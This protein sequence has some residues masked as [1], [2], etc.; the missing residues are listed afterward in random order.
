MRNHV[1]KFVNTMPAASQKRGYGAVRLTPE[2][3]C[4]ATITATTRLG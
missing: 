3:G 4:A 2:N 1:Q